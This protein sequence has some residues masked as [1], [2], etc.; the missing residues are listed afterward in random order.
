MSTSSY[1]LLQ[2]LIETVAL[3]ESN[4]VTLYVYGIFTLPLT[5]QSLIETVAATSYDIPV[6][7]MTDKTQ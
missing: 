5:L 1:N 7:D 4:R 2:S 3:I 6:Q